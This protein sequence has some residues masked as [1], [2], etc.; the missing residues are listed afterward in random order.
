MT[1]SI[2]YSCNIRINF[3]HIHAVLGKLP[4]LQFSG[5][6]TNDEVLSAFQRTDG[7]HSKRLWRE[8]VCRDAF[9]YIFDSFT[10]WYKI[11]RLLSTLAS[12]FLFRWSVIWLCSGYFEYFPS[13]IMNF[14][15]WQYFGDV[16]SLKELREGFIS[17][18]VMYCNDEIC[19]E[20][21]ILNKIFV[22]SFVVLIF[23]R[24]EV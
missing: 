11:Y 7:I 14:N 22:E 3:I 20:I 2:V 9:F 21:I 16:S 13:R 15:S 17:N 24:S 19:W 6:F 12:W 23:F 1:L 18:K 8:T 10:I 5:G 4:Y